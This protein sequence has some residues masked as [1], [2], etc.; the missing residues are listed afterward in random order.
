M[1]KWRVGRHQTRN[2]YYTPDGTAERE[3]FRGVF[4]DPDEGPRIAEALNGSHSP[5]LAYA[6]DLLAQQVDP[7]LCQF[8]HNHSC[9]EHGYFYLEP[10]EMCPEQQ[11]KMF[12]ESHGIDWK[13]R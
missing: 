7:N 11:T 5:E 6:L 8:D 9:Q 4:F 12:L 3:E 10:G 1:G 2:L 13:S